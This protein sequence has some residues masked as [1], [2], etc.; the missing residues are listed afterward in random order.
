[1]L[2]D[3]IIILASNSP[4]LYESF[5]LVFIEA[6]AIKVP[7]VAFNT[8]AANEIITDDETGLLVPVNSSQALADKIIYVLQ[9]PGE[10]NRMAVNGNKKYVDYFNTERM[11]KDTVNWYHTIMDK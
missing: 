11:V 3:L 7:V 10:G 1:M 5:G 8:P 2:M 6:F 4:S 9:N